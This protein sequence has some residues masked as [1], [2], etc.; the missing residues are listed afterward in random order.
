MLDHNIFPFHNI[1]N[2]D[3]TYL[4]NEN[5]LTNLRNFESSYFDPLC[6][7]DS[8]DSNID[9]DVGNFT[10][11]NNRSIS[12][13]KYF[14]YADLHGILNSALSIPKFEIISQNIRS[15]NENVNHF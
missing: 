4:F 15:L 2:D 12:F 3:L 13:S 10:S 6:V 14:Q 8:Y 1:N 9:P 11:V 5:T 7:S